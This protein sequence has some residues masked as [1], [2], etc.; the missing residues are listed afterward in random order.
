MERCGHKSL[1]YNYSLKEI[2]KEKK[3]NNGWEELMI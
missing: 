3:V 2:R 1:L